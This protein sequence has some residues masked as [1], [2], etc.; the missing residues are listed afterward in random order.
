MQYISDKSSLLRSHGDCRN[1][2]ESLEH[3]K[4]WAIFF[5][6]SPALCAASKFEAAVDFKGSG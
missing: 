2:S 5:I 4:S 1:E 3:H 6:P